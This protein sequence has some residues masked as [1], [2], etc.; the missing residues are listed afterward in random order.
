MK[1][2]LGNWTY[3]GKCEKKKNGV[4]SKTKDR[5]LF[6]LQVFKSKQ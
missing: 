3:R 1:K 5:G 4:L 2:G 6:D